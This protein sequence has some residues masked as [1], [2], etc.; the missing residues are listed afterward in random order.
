MWTPTLETEERERIRSLRVAMN[1]LQSGDRPTSDQ[2][3]ELLVSA[4]QA[5]ATL[6]RSTR[7]FPLLNDSR[8]LDKA[9][10][11]NHIPTTELACQLYRCWRML[12]VAAATQ[13]VLLREV[14]MTIG[15]TTGK[16]RAQ[17][18]GGL[19]KNWKK[20]VDAKAHAGFAAEGPG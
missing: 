15:T 2:V 19:T 20:G 17:L 13:K 10:A 7:L 8:R 12:G 9:R 14:F 1:A 4:L 16:A 11:L 5:Q 18:F 3:D 6:I